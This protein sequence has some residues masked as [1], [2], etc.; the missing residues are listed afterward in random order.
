[1]TLDLAHHAATD[2][3]EPGG[4]G[5]QTKPDESSTV[6]ADSDADL[7]GT[8]PSTGLLFGHVRQVQDLV[9][10]VTAERALVRRRHVAPRNA[11]GLRDSEVVRHLRRGIL[12]D[13]EGHAFGF[14]IALGVITE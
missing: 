4:H 1:M 3:G 13:P 12:D 7:I 2:H 5:C 11:T 14:D 8:N 6:D 9:V 10:A